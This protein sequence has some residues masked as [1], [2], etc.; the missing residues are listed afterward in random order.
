MMLVGR[1]I[2]GVGAGGILVMTEIIFTGMVPLRERG[3]WFGFISGVGAIGSVIRTIMGGA[4]TE[5]GSLITL[6]I[7]DQFTY[8]WNWLRSGRSLPQATSR[9]I[10][11][12]CRAV[13]E[14]GMM[15]GQ[16]AYF[17]IFIHGVVLW[18][19]LY[20]GPIHYEGVK[21]LSPVITDVAMFPETFTIAVGFVTSIIG[22]YH[23]AL[24]TEASS[25]Y[26]SNFFLISFWKMAP[27]IATPTPCPNDRR[28]MK[29]ETACAMPTARQAAEVAIVLLV[30]SI[31]VPR[32]GT[33]LSNIQATVV[34]ITMCGFSAVA[35]FTTFFVKEYT[36]DQELETDQGFK[37][38]GKAVD[39]ELS[40]M[41]ENT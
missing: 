33:R 7:L 37:H 23:W 25:G 6:D 18:T 32:P 13:E 34:W 8:R 31:P 21:N 39:S 9:E 14:G 30:Y 20:Y 29:K 28:K 3:R 27:P 4:F 1:S 16:L 10:I 12:A 17:Q 2:Q 11:F 15:T 24:W 5:D 19:L 22:K 40:I 36:I 38:H 26:E 41:G 35:L